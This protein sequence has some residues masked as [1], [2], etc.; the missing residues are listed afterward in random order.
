MRDRALTFF[1]R[2]KFAFL[3]LILFIGAAGCSKSR[4]VI[5]KTNPQT[6]RPTLINVEQRGKDT[7]ADLQVRQE[8]IDEGRKVPVDIP[9]GRTIQVVLH[10]AMA[11]GTFRRLKG[12]AP[13][14][15]GDLLIRVRITAD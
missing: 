6:N 12:Q 3:T 7:Y 2:R 9:D 13:G 1:S 15:T 11:D 5:P 14:G 10:A 8:W 4:K